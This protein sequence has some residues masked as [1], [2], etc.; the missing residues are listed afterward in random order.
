[1]SNNFNNESLNFAVARLMLQ[2]VRLYRNNHDCWNILRI[3][4]DR[5]ISK[6][7]FNFAKKFVNCRL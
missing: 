6:R 1:M 4:S 5:M 3:L 7:V 2:K